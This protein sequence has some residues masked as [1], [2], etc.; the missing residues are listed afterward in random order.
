MKTPLSKEVGKLRQRKSKKLTAVNAHL[1][2]TK[3]QAVSVHVGYQSTHS[4]RILHLPACHMR[5]V[6]R[7]RAV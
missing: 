5:A 2:T 1:S 6:S 7:P 3:E 4:L